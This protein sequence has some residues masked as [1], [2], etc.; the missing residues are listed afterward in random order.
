MGVQRR[1]SK[2]RS[3]ITHKSRKSRSLRNKSRKSRRNRQC[4]GYG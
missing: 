2:K 1:F 4:G 3:N